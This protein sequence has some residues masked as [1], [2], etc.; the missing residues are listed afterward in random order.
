MKNGGRKNGVIKD[1]VMKDGVV[2]NGVMK[3]G[4]MKDGIE[5]FLKTGRFQR[6]PSLLHSSDIHPW[7]PLEALS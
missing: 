7:M 6:S 2:K 4:V 1:G 3:D 5:E